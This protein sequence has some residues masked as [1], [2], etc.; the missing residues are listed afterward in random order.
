MARFDA[1]N[2]AVASY[3]E[4][5]V[6]KF[7]YDPR[8]CDYGRAESQRI[9]F[10]AITRVILEHAGPGVPSVLDVGCGF[11]DLRDHLVANRL[12]V[13]YT[14]VE[15]VEVMARVARARRPDLR[16]VVADALDARITGEPFDIVVANGLFYLRTPDFDAYFD[17]MFE[18]LFALSTRLTL[19][20][21][22]SA[23]A[24]TK[25]EG[26]VYFDPADLAARAGR[27]TRRFALHHDY[28]RHDQLL[29]LHHESARGAD[30]AG[31]EGL[32]S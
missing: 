3:Y 10:E 25:N 12:V 26:E 22:L 1:H 8:A 19:I 7:G 15:I 31:V 29:V 30:T 32:P 9:K 13:E 28:M 21:L 17:S 27:L 20:T 6:A 11:G 4:E 2:Q 5:L 14:G 18:R 24:D 23:H 16:I